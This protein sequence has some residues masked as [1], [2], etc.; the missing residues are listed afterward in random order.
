MLEA[1]EPAKR[2]HGW[3]PR[4]SGGTR[5]ALW[6]LSGL[7]LMLI[8]GGVAAVTE[9]INDPL[10]MDVLAGNAPVN[11]PEAES[12][13]VIAHNSPTV[14]NSPG[15]N[16]NLAV[17]SQ[18]D[19]PRRSCALYVS[20]D[21]GSTWQQTAIPTPERSS[22]QCYSPDT[23]FGADG[24]LYILYGTLPQEAD[25][26]NA[27][28]LASSND[29]GLSVSQ[30]QQVLDRPALQARLA[31][32]PDK[33]GRLYTTWTQPS[34]SGIQAAVT[35]DGG[36]SWS[37][38]VQVS[39]PGDG[40]V[41]GPSPE[42]G[43]AA[44]YVAYV[45]L[46]DERSSADGGAGNGSDGSARQVVLAR[47]SDGGSTWAQARV[48]RLEAANEQQIP[49]L[50]AP[51]VAV[52]DRGSVHV[53][54]HDT[55]LGEDA[56]VWLSTSPDQGRTWQETVRVNRN[57]GTDGTHQYQPDVEVAP[58]GRVDVAYYDRRTDADQLVNVSLQSSSDGGETFTDRLVLSDQP[59][60]SPTAR[61]GFDGPRDLAKPLGLISTEGHTLAVWT[62]T[63]ASTIS[64]RKQDLAHALVGFSGG[65][66]LPSTGVTGL[67][68]ASVLLTLVGL[69][70]FV[71]WGL[72]RRPGAGVD[73]QAGD[74]RD[75]S[76]VST[77][78][79]VPTK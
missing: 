5:S 66:G 71:A 64:P 7:A 38:P 36:R 26:P 18:V 49:V 22:P 2:R 39:D 59:F 13:Q 43:T 29:G 27:L 37:D 28:W 68:M 61:E 11:P 4:G 35:D 72:G 76:T 60:H 15:D 77:E 42:V 69:G 31:A 45:T 54:F 55:R 53:A 75:R 12:D 10:Q 16:S 40:L 24:T 50:P 33:P 67:R 70:L 56:D 21:G 3:S 78:P 57:A 44:A 51:S 74:S 8:G 62:D 41:A 20:K 52:N 19:F 23:A 25:A 48:N 32:D 65:S 9:A 1:G 79:S 47:T 63:R 6:A 34:Q 17:A 46:G 73:V 58:S 30:P 14:A